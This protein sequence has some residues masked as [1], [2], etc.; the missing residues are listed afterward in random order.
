MRHD[1]ES[2]GTKAM[3]EW[4]NGGE[5][6]FKNTVRDYQFIENRNLWK[7]GKPKLRGIK[8]LEALCKDKGYEFKD[9]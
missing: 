4:A 2:C 1:A 3:T 8:L 7:A 9:E 5:C 6:P